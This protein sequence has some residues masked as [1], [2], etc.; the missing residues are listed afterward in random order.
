MKVLLIKNTFIWDVYFVNTS[1]IRSHEDETEY[2]IGASV[3]TYR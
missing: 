1:V 2:V 3:V